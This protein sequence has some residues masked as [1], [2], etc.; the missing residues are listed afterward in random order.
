MSSVPNE[1][2]PAMYYLSYDA[3]HIAELK[4]ELAELKHAKSADTTHLQTLY[5]YLVQDIVTTLGPSLRESNTSWDEYIFRDSR[6]AYKLLEPHVDRF[7]AMMK[8]IVHQYERACHFSKMEAK[9][10]ATTSTSVTVCEE[11][12]LVAFSSFPEGI[13]G[14]RDDLDLVVV[15]NEDNYDAMYAVGRMD[16]LG[17][18]DRPIKNEDGDWNRYGTVKNPEMYGMTGKNIKWAGIYHS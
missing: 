12:V 11:P 14:N 18:L 16:S 13:F 2:V 3:D 17:N 9:Y 4:Q 7:L 5:D 8:S 15:Y 1:S 10:D 6:M